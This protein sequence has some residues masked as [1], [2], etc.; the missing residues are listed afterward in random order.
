MGHSRPNFQ[1]GERCTSF[2]DTNP[3]HCSC[4][5]VANASSSIRTPTSILRIW[6]RSVKFADVTNVLRRSTT[7][8]LACRLTKL[9]G[10][11]VRGS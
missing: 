5:R 6:P 11:T 10:W 7:M 1:T 8:H 2:A 9:Y 4:K 3:H